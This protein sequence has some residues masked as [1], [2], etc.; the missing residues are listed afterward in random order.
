LY[1]NN[2][3]V[4][5]TSRNIEFR[6]FCKFD[7]IIDYFLFRLAIFSERTKKRL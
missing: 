5:I 6:E 2:Y 3:E 4:I 7:N 1:N